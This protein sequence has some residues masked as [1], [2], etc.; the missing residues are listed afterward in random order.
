MF[1]VDRSSPAEQPEIGALIQKAHK[2]TS[3]SLTHS[4][5]RDELSAAELR[6]AATASLMYADAAVSFSY[7]PNHAC[8]GEY[9]TPRGFQFTVARTAPL[10]ATPFPQS[11]MFNGVLAFPLDKG[12]HCN[13]T[14]KGQSLRPGYFSKS[15]VRKSIDNFIK[16]D[17]DLGEDET[18]YAGIFST[19]VRDGFE[20]KLQYWAV[21]QCH[22][23]KL[24]EQ[25]YD[26][27]CDNEARHGDV[28]GNKGKWQTWHAFF[29]ND[30]RVNDIMQKQRCHRAEVLC[31]LI[32]AC[33]LGRIAEST[34]K[35]ENIN[36]LLNSPDAVH[37]DFN[38]VEAV[39][40]DNLAF[41]SDLVSYKSISSSGTVVR[42]PSRLGLALLRGPWTAPAK[43]L[44]VGFPCSTG[45]RSS[46]RGRSLADYSAEERNGM[47]PNETH[48]WERASQRPLNVNLATKDA[49]LREDRRWA[50]IEACLGYN[51]K[52]GVVDLRPVQVKL[53]ST[54]QPED[55]EL[56]TDR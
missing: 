29:M 21:V 48:F 19:T 22:S 44:E 31:K 24:S 16:E 20:N 32:R 27:L 25:F 15:S 2:K 10:Y 52:N 53:H 18:N 23:T 5:K 14:T 28:D 6:F 46:V 13:Q 11:N 1:A 45:H 12:L 38:A 54:R 7:A 51:R 42:E 26:Y 56:Y 55:N 39:D 47:K 40:E 33:G 41:L 30:Q 43:A 50:A 17:S 36:F 9:E 49:N 35:E 37:V 4:R 3:W 8:C 34:S